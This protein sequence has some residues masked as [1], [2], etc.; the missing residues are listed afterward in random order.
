ME[1]KTE[2]EGEVGERV[3]E[4]KKEGEV[5]G[6]AHMQMTVYQQRQ[7]VHHKSQREGETREKGEI[8]ERNRRE[9]Q[10]AR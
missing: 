9:N 7:T 1:E 2:R 10:N 6:S 3:R 5:D 4:R 8:E